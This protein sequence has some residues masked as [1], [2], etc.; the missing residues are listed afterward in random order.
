MVS[1]F[2]FFSKTNNVMGKDKEGKFQPSK[3]RPS[4]T[5]KVIDQPLHLSAPGALEN[6][7]EIADKYT[8]GSAEEATNVRI[9]HPN[10]NVHKD[11]ERS[12]SRRD[13][14][15][16]NR[17]T[18][19]T[20]RKAATIQKTVQ[21]DEYLVLNKEAFHE[22]A[23]Y[24]ASRCIS[25][26]MPT[27]ESG[28]AVNE[29]FDTITFKNKLQQ[30]AAA[31]RSNDTDHTL[32]DRLLDPGYKLLNNQNFWLNLSKGLAVFIADG[33]FSYFKMPYAPKEDMMI[34][35]SFYLSPLIPVMTQNEHFFLLVL[36]KKQARFY[37]A[38]AFG[39]KHIPLAEMPNGI[40]DVV[41]LEE[42]DDQKLWRTGS[43]GAGGGAN[44]HGIGAGKPDDKENIAMYLDE[45]DETLWKEVLHNQKAPLLLAGVE[46]LLPIYRQVAKY[47]HLWPTS[48]TGSHEYDD[49][50]SLYQQARTLMQ[51]YFEDR[52]KKAMAD[53]GDQSALSTTSFIIDEVIPAAFYSRVAQLFAVQGEHIWGTFDEQENELAIHDT[54]QEGDDCLLD[55]VVIK[56]LLNGGE[57][58]LVT[59]EQMPANSR[60]AARLRY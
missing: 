15:Q 53:Y 18:N 31:L 48:L 36:S 13:T 3:G 45:V 41:H 46:Y 59:K 35:T 16:N 21:P 37:R 30:I 28:S 9:R 42:K 55:K 40:E 23:G 12:Q 29:K 50:H 33:K 43:S 19:D 39:M 11:E 34:N 4:G 5:G 58:F 24:H 57:V 52:Y 7:L 8:T 26:Y 56:T 10:R 1:L 32:I 27:H 47:G 25:V 51:P 60:L 17:G 6:Y 14:Q 20:M 54:Q 2:C 22:L 44:Y 49:I 38:D